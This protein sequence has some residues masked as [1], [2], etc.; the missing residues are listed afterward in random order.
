MI[1]NILSQCGLWSYLKSCMLIYTILYTRNGQKQG[2][3]SQ[4]QVICRNCFPQCLA[5][6]FT[7]ELL[8][9]WSLCYYLNK[10]YYLPMSWCNYEHDWTLVYIENTSLHI[11]RVQKVLNLNFSSAI[12]QFCIGMK[13]LVSVLASSL[14]LSV[15]YSP[16]L[17]NS[18][19]L[20]IFPSFFLL[21]SVKISS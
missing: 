17:L 20:P 7:L 18:L 10:C 1:P 2:I 11:F 15:S 4:S 14:C 6:Q 13:S 16:F 12:Y 19:P 3:L 8:A 21:I 5:Q 9:D